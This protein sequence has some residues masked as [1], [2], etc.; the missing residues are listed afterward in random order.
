ML[1]QHF[2]TMCFE[3]VETIIS[4]D[5]VLVYHWL[6]CEAELLYLHIYFISTCVQCMST[7][8]Y[9]EHFSSVPVSVL[10]SVST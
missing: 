2:D 4:V 5:S 1:P 10:R 6:S 7:V 8:S 3:C 9:T